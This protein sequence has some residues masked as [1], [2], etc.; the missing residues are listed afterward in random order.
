MG[1]TVQTAPMA[2]KE[3][4]E[5]VELWEQVEAVLVAQ[6]RPGLEVPQE[7]VEEAQILHVEDRKRSA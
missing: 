4:P 5:P 2:Q 3:Q 6:A 1:Q 7:P